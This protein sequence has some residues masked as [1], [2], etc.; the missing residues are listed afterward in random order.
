MHQQHSPAMKNRPKPTKVVPPKAPPAKKTKKGPTRPLYEASGQARWQGNNW[1]L[2]F[3][4][5]GGTEDAGHWLQRLQS[6]CDLKKLVLQQAIVAK[7]SHKDG[8]PHLHMVFNLKDKL[9]TRDC[10]YWD[11]VVGK[12]CNQQTCRDYTDC[13]VYA[14]KTFTDIS[15]LNLNLKEFMEAKKNKKSTKCDR[16]A[17]QLQN[18]KTIQEVAK[19]D[20]GFFMLNMPKII[21]Y[22]NFLKRSAVEILPPLAGATSDL[23]S[24]PNSYL[25]SYVNNNYRGNFTPQSK[26]LWI[27]GDTKIGKSTFVNELRK[28]K[29][30]YDVPYDGD[31]YDGFDETFDIALFDE[32]SGRKSIQWL[33][34]FLDPF[35]LYMNKRNTHGGYKKERHIPSIVLT[36]LLPEQV[37]KKINEKE[38]E[39]LRALMRRFEVITFKDEL[40]RVELKTKEESPVFELAPTQVIEEEPLSTPGTP[41][42]RQLLRSPNKALVDEVEDLSRRYYSASMDEA[43]EELQDS[44]EVEVVEGLLQIRHED[45]LRVF[46]ESPDS[47]DG[48]EE[49]FQEELFNKKRKHF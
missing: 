17:A 28:Y 35:P 24:F 5:A 48:K 6:F 40:L 38:P 42:P 3:P 2:T 14:G 27:V 29:K 46:T 36:N 31:W 16:V 21:A 19:A 18:G 15:C 32:F 47:D 49:L 41:L 37:Y 13:V 20:P 39:Y 23:T 33:N 45:V 7:E 22:D 34:R 25:A 4:K 30:V 12:H 43:E 44:D 1:F 11:P 26:H 10:R 8:E 9:S